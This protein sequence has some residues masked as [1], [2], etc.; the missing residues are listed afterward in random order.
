MNNSGRVDIQRGRTS[1]TVCTEYYASAFVVNVQFPSSRECSSPLLPVPC[2]IEYRLEGKLC[3]FLVCFRNFSPESRKGRLFFSAKHFP[4]LQKNHP[5]WS[6]VRNFISTLP[7]FP[8]YTWCECGLPPA[9]S[10]TRRRR[11][12]RFLFLPRAKLVSAISDVGS[13]RSENA[14]ATIEECGSEGLI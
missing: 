4:P 11:R 6:S 12:R 7:S 8:K 5:P 13:G 1:W 14:A 2:V 10:Q 3:L 9:V